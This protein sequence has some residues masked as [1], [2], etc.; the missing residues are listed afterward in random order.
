MRTSGYHRR[1]PT[2]RHHQ[3]AKFICQARRLQE[4]AKQVAVAA[5]ED[6]KGI[7]RADLPGESLNNRRAL[8]LEG[9]EKPVPDGEADATTVAAG[10]A[11]IYLG[12]EPGV[13]F[14]PATPFRLQC[15]AA[16]IGLIETLKR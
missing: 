3:A 16:A 10:I 1:L 13:K 11:A 4:I 15:R 8:F 14:L 9:P 5:Q 7:D 6:D 2:G 12:S